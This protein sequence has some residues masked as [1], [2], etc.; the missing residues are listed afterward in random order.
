MY[1]NFLKVITIL[2]LIVVSN[3]GHSISYDNQQ[4]VNSD[5]TVD[6]ISK[7]F[8]AVVDNDLDTVDMLLNKNVDVNIPDTKGNTPLML[9]IMLGHENVFERL[10]AHPDIDVNVRSDDGF[11]AFLHAKL[12][13]R[14]DFERGQRMVSLLKPHIAHELQLSSMYGRSD[15]IQDIVFQIQYGDS[16]DGDV[17]D[18]INSKD[19]AQSGYD[20]ISYDG[21]RTGNTPIMTALLFGSQVP[22]ELFVETIDMLSKVRN[23]DLTIR[24]NLGQTPL[25]M[26]AMYN[27]EVVPIL[28]AQDSN[29]DINAR[30]N[31]GKSAIDIARESNYTNI[32]SNLETIFASRSGVFLEAAKNNDLNT[33][34]SLIDSYVNVK[35]SNGN[36]ALIEA[37]S[38]GNTRVVRKLLSHPNI[39]VNEKTSRNDHT[40]LTIAIVRS[41]TEVIELILDHPKTNLNLITGQGRNALMWA[42]FLGEVGVVRD[43]ILNGANLNMQ[44]R[45]LGNTALMFAAE[46]GRENVVRIILNSGKYIENH[47]NRLRQTAAMIAQGKRHHEMSQ[48][49]NSFFRNQGKR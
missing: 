9:A 8:I 6:D 41:H 42:S 15:L 39:R 44:D 32:A 18:I 45:F 43:L 49:L 5:Q 28:L 38:R 31:D 13:R 37:S 17:S 34:N 35:D 33:I 12:M 2:F 24:N 7:L 26:A 20:P 10:L 14:K 36:T 16:R 46:H 27:P 40:A 19:V 1:F 48:L 30:D 11:T 47:R 3:T 23:L 4:P 29:L 22:K 21:I 25:I